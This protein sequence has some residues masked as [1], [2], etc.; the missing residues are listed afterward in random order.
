M[1]AKELGKFGE[2]VAALYMEKKGYKILRRNFCVKGGEID[3][4][5]EKDGIIA[6]TEVKTDEI[7]SVG[8][9]MLAAAEEQIPEICEKIDRTGQTDDGDRKAILAFAKAFIGKSES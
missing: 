6:F 7:L 3:I 8:R 2:N 9:A 4:I 5:A 1:T